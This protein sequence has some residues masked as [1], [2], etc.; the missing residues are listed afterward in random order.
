[1][2]VSLDP[3]NKA[4]VSPSL[5]NLKNHI[6]YIQLWVTSNFLKVNEDKTSILYICL[7]VCVCGFIILLQVSKTIPFRVK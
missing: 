2:Y 7:C 3:A 1:M 4:D 6:A 5:E